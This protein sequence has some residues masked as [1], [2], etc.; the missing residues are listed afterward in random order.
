MRR[1]SWVLWLTIALAA[2]NKA[3]EDQPAEPPTEKETL[4]MC[5]KEVRARAFDPA[6]AKVPDVQNAGKGNLYTF[7]WGPATSPVLMNDG[8]GGT[9]KLEANCTVD[10]DTNTIVS[11]NV[12][13]Q[14]YVGKDVTPPPPPGAPVDRP[15]TDDP[16]TAPA[17]ALAPPAAPAPSTP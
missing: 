9:T 7:V 1:E 13:G 12:D 16:A 11:L 10:A 3:T 17:P 4:A 14:Q 6:T 2:C 15:V 8:F 5:Q